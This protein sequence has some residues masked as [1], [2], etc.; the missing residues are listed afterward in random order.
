M[1]I[2]WIPPLLS[3]FCR[4]RAFLQKWG[5]KRSSCF[6]LNIDSFRR[7]RRL[8]RRRRHKN[9]FGRKILP[10]IR[11]HNRTPPHTLDG[12][13][14][15]LCQKWSILFRKS[16]RNFEK[17]LRHFLMKILEEAEHMKF[18]EFQE[19]PEKS[20]IFVKKLYFQRRIYCRIF[21]GLR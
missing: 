15:K 11:S 18:A 6:N 16:Q 4:N 9:T 1:K 7:S 21:V 12:E 10:S 20:E 14:R 17:I 13:L 19:I 2:G 5:K 3:I 8:R